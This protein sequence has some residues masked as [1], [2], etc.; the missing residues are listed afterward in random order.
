MVSLFLLL[1]IYLFPSQIC[2]WDHIQT[3]AVHFT[4]DVHSVSIG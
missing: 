4:N 1:M 3:L 2:E